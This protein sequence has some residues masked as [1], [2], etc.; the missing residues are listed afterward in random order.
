MN[1]TDRRPSTHDH[2]AFGAPC[3]HR[4]A[5]GAQRLCASELVEFQADKPPT[6]TPAICIACAVRNYPAQQRSIVLRPLRRSPH[7]PHL[8]P[9]THLKIM[10]AQL[11]A[12][13]AE[14]CNCPAWASQMNAWGA[15]GCREHL[16]EIIE[17]LQEARSKITWSALAG[18]GKKAIALGLPKTIKGLIR[19]S[20]RR[21][22][23]LQESC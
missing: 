6:V 10:L 5:I 11:G 15:A 18:M 16:R 4:H 8:G 22:E 19:E 13:Q 3:S 14:G 1:P 2:K 12:Y 9:G 7:V 17:H 20:I 23:S 21:A